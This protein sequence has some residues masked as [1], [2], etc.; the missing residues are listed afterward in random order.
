MARD[1]H[2]LKVA[3]VDGRDEGLG[4]AAWTP[5]KE[6]APSIRTHHRRPGILRQQLGWSGHVP[7]GAD[8]GPAATSSGRIVGVTGRIGTVEAAQHEQDRIQAAR[9]FG[10]LET[11][12]STNGARQ[13]E[14]IHI[15]GVDAQFRVDITIKEEGRVVCSAQ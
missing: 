8:R 13:R 14:L 4:V 2:D 6:D 12:A 1:P 5:E 10:E 3:D 7:A 9:A 11:R 15:I